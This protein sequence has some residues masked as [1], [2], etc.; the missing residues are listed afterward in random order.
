MI[1]N[2]EKHDRYKQKYLFLQA[3]G[4]VTHSNAI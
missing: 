1:K 4:N 2:Q 3:K